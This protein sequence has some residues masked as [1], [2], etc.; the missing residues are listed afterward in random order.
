MAEGDP[1]LAVR[2]LHVRFRTLDGTVEAVKGIN[3][4]V[5]ASETVA[6]GG[7]SG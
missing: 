6:I 1:I 3:L 7:E 4:H 5:K 2:D